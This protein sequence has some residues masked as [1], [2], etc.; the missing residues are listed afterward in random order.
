MGEAGSGSVSGLVAGTLG[1][2]GIKAEDINERAGRF[3]ITGAV[4]INGETFYHNGNGLL[5]DIGDVCIFFLEEEF[6]G[7]ETEGEKF[8]PLDQTQN[9][10]CQVLLE[11]K[12]P[13]QP[14]VSGRPSP[15]E[16]P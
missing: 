4:E 6:Y 16:R 7:P 2:L 8:S 9:E 1:A 12:S 5:G 11:K 13:A 15:T 3:Y 10:A 14:F